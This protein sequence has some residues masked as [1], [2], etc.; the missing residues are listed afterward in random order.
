MVTG[1]LSSPKAKSGIASGFIKS[2]TGT[3]CASAWPGKGGNV[4]TPSTA[5]LSATVAVL[6]QNSRRVICN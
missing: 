2:A 1:A 6:R 4:E 5:R 3:F